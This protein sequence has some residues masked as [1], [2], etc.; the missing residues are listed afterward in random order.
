[1]FLVSPFL[2]LCISSS[3]LSGREN[4]NLSCQCQSYAGEVSLCGRPGSPAGGVLDLVGGEGSPLYLPGTLARYRCQGRLAR[5]RQCQEDG[6]WSGEVPSCTKS[7]AF[8]RSTLQSQPD[9]QNGSHL[10]VDGGQ[11]HHLQSVNKKMDFKAKLRD[12]I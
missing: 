9:S 1:M 5:T 10:A 4:S 2:L 3:V 6:R 11:Y 12:L 7:L 8:N